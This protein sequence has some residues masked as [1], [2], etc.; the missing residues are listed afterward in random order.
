MK[1]ATILREAGIYPE[2]F[3]KCGEIN[4]VLYDSDDQIHE[5][6]D[7]KFV[8][9][10]FYRNPDSFNKFVDF[11]AEL[12]TNPD[13]SAINVQ[14]TETHVIVFY[15]TPC[16]KVFRRTQPLDPIDYSD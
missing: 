5:G 8:E 15:K 6:D 13:N 7:V 1:F 10:L 12:D 2:L 3:P 11:V 14:I 16:V 9:S 4:T